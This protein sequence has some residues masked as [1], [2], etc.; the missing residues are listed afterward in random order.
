M[1]KISFVIPC[2]GSEHTI[3]HVVTGIENIVRPEDDYEVILVNDCSPD[4]VWEKIKELCTRNPKVKGICLSKNFGQH[5]ALLAGYRQ[6]TGDLVVSLDDDG[7]TPVEEVY[8]LIDTAAEGADVAMAYYPNKMH[9]K[10]RNIGSRINQIMAVQLVGM[11]KVIINTSY[12]CMHRFVVE[13]MLRYTNAYPYIPGL[14]CRTTK[15]IKNVAIDHREREYGHSGY[16]LKKLLGLWFNG[17][18]AFSIKP[19]RIATATGCFCAIAG[20]VFGFVTIIR[21][22][23]NPNMML[24]WSSLVSLLVFIGGMI[25]LMLGLIGEYIGRIYICINNSPQYV[26]KEKINAETKQAEDHC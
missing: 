25:M 21:K 5:G 20:F 14:L 6:C 4:N 1:R 13:E 16:T 17:F 22:F 23:V 24:G 11:P 26:I 10:F 7:Q 3:E 18:T 12:F 19:L 2:Y 15:N 9:N 8:R